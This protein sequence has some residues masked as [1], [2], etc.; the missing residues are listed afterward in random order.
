[1]AQGDTF[2]WIRVQTFCYSTEDENLI[3]DTMAQLIGKDEFD[4]EVCEGEHGNRMIILQ[5]EMRKQKEFVTMFSALPSPLIERVS[6]EADDRVDDDCIL[7]IRLDKQKAVT[8]KYTMAHHGDV[9]SITAKI[10]SHPARKEIAVR[11]L[12]EFLS[13]LTPDQNPVSDEE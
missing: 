6:K 12:R 9:I 5:D 1:M 11:N 4:A 2:H 3:H 7:Y 13:K 10:V 8:G